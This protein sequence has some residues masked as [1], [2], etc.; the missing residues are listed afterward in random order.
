MAEADDAR[1]GL[2]TPPDPFRDGFSGARMLAARSA[3]NFVSIWRIVGRRFATRRPDYPKLR[4]MRAVWA[5]LMLFAG[6][7]VLLDAPLAAFRGHWPPGVMA[8]AETVTD[9]GLSGW[10]LGAAALVLLVVNLTRWRTRPR[11]RLLALYNWTGLAMYTL[12]AV[13]VSGLVVNVLKYGI[14]RSRPQRFLDFGAYSFDPFAMEAYSAS[15]PSG[16]STT[17]GAVAGMLWLF[18]PRQRYLIAPIAIWCAATRAVVGA[19]YPSDILAGLALGFAMALLAAVVFAR[20]GYVFRQVPD[21]LPAL[22]RSFR[23]S[24]N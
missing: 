20:L 7:V 10:Y 11:R 22:R 17:M 23:L 19:H 18:F 3:A 4:P 24:G 1:K 2:R 15:F 21:G 12:A 14:G 13:G 8:L 6:S 16:H 9:V 5:F